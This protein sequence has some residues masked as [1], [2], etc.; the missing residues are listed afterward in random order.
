MTERHQRNYKI[1][2]LTKAN[3]VVVDV[4]GD[5]RDSREGPAAWM[6]PWLPA[7]EIAILR[8]G[9]TSAG[10]ERGTPQGETVDV[11]DRGAS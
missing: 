7:R 2:G 11:P 9:L 3:T 5:V 4:D 10:Y 8:R 1:V 6:M